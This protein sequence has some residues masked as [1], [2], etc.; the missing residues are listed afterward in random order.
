MPVSTAPEGEQ[1]DQNPMSS[2]DILGLSKGKKG[3]KNG[4]ETDGKAI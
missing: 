2:V 3:T 4:T 1:V